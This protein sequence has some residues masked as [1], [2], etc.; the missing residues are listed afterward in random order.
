MKLVGPS[1]IPLTVAAAR[2]TETLQPKVA[3]MLPRLDVPKQIDE[4]IRF[5]GPRRTFGKSVSVVVP[6]LWP[7]AAT[8]GKRL[9]NSIVAS[10][11]A[12]R[13]IAASFG[14]FAAAADLLPPRLVAQTKFV[15]KKVNKTPQ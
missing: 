6:L 1:K 11:S 14:R 4:T 7:A 12:G 9:T 15:E 13:A 2:S 5:V 10:F 3:G 8:D